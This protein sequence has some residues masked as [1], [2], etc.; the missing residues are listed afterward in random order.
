MPV[1]QI[2]W[3]TTSSSI[4]VL[5]PIERVES[6]YCHWDHKLRYDGG[7]FA[8]WTRLIPA[9]TNSSQKISCVEKVIEDRPKGSFRTCP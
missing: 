1:G 9:L 6:V 4:V 8:A 2:T 7:V 5:P 3:S